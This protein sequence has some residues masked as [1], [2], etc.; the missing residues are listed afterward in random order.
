MYYKVWSGLTKYIRQVLVTGYKPIE[1]KDFAIFAPT[2]KSRLHQR[3]AS[4]AASPESLLRADTL[5]LKHIQQNNGFRNSSLN[6]AALAS[7]VLKKDSQKI[8]LLLL[9]RF[10]QSCGGDSSLRVPVVDQER[11]SLLLDETMEFQE[12]EQLRGLRQINS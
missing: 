12:R 11:V 1:I 6:K 10:I 8:R 3:S 5:S 2:L 7:E 4:D 9:P